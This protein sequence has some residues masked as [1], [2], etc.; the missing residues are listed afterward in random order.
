LVDPPL[1]CFVVEPNGID[2]H[3]ALHG[4]AGEVHG[5]HVSLGKRLLRAIESTH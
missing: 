3:H 2:K 4:A 5:R 1:K